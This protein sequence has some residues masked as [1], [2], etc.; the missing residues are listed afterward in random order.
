[1]KWLIPLGI[2]GALLIAVIAIVIW[3]IGISNSEV[4]LRNSFSAQIKANETNY[5]N[6]WKTI[7]Q[8]Y[9]LSGD[10]K[11]SMVEVIN[12]AAAGRKGGSL[13]KSVTEAMP[14]IDSSIIKGVMATIEGKRND[15]ESH[16]KML[17]D[18]KRE[19]D[20]MRTTIPSSWIVGGRAELV[21][22]LV[23]SDRTN[24]AFN[25]GVDNDVKL[26]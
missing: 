1:M 14:G 17:V 3:A 15:F 7:Q 24:D 8:K 2:I 4:R 5:D 22:K 12:A 10:Y 16:Q 9:Q 23:T 26:K 20:N 11:D 13:V 21:L 6:L 18:L 19:H 25:S